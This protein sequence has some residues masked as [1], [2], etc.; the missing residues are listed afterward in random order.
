MDN[1]I[2]KT[3]SV[4]VLTNP[5]LKEVTYVPATD[6][7]LKI[8]DKGNTYTLGHLLADVETLTR[9]YNKLLDILMEDR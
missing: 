4:A 8:D 5:K 2:G 7:V 1:R 9:N 3:N 6:I